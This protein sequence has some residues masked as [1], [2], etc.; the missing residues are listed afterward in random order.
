MIMVPKLM[1]RFQLE[2]SLS[3]ILSVQKIVTRTTIYYYL[4]LNLI[5]I[6]TMTYNEES[7]LFSWHKLMTIRGKEHCL[8]AYMNPYVPC[9]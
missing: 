3:V 4:D 7:Y 8:E 9:G 2:Y 1:E 5:S 6:P